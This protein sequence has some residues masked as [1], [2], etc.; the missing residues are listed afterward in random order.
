MNR[1]AM[2][3]A[4]SRNLKVVAILAGFI[5]VATV[6]PASAA[7]LLTT[8][9]SSC[10][11]YGFNATWK[12]FQPFSIPAAATISAISL[13]ANTGGDPSLFSVRIYADSAGVPSNTLLGTFAYGSTS[14]FVGRFTGNIPL[15]SAG[16]YWIYISA[17]AQV[18]ACFTYSAVTTGSV[19]NWTLSRV[20]EGG[21]SATPAT[22]GDDGTF[23]FSLEGTGGGFQPPTSSISLGG[24]AFA[25][26][27]QSMTISA[28][29][30]VAGT[31]GKVTFYANGTK[32]PGCIN[33]PSSSLAVSCSWKPSTRGAIVITSRIVPTDTGFS[34]ST[35][36]GKTILV[37]NRSTR[38]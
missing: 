11:N 5:T 2:K 30:G 34:A 20:F 26:Y 36:V 28:S 35:S 7:E 15:N 37:S 24:S 27:R 21:I 33:K 38:R 8:L 13:K 29:L 19:P 10:S 31:D 25:T 4:A 32:I 3:R 1:I 18:Y 16:R 9:N 6:Q 17:S 23:L 22:R 12:A 14:N